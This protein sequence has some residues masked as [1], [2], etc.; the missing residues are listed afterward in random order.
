[1]PKPEISM[2]VVFVCGCSLFVSWGVFLVVFV[3]FFC[4]LAPPPPP[5]PHPYTWMSFCVFC[6]KNTTV[7]YRFHYSWLWAERKQGSFCLEKLL[8]AMSHIEM[9]PLEEKGA[10]QGSQ[11]QPGE[12]FGESSLGFYIDVKKNTFFC[13]NC[14]CFQIWTWPTHL[15]TSFQP[16]FAQ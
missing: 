2:F 7:N 15:K 5:P 8:L 16:T 10:A 9:I 4:L 14:E 11:P 3:V 1:M 12:A 13:G 6:M